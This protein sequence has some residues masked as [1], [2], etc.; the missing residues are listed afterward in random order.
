MKHTLLGLIAALF[1]VGCSSNKPN[2][3]EID[4]GYYTTVQFDGC[5]YLVSTSDKSIAHKGNCKNPI[6]LYNKVETNVTPPVIKN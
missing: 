4:G 6:H 3:V 2:R 5:E 1:V